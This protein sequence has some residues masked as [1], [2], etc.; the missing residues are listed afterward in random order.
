MTAGL[1]LAT[2]VA[3]L[4]VCCGDEGPKDPV[5]GI[6]MQIDIGR[7]LSGNLALTQVKRQLRIYR[8]LQGRYPDTLANLEADGTFR[9]PSP[10]AGADFYYDPETGA[11]RVVQ[12]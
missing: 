8:D 3:V 9:L 1:A 7:T 11:V 2:A 4:G 10:G 12:R 5:D 6:G